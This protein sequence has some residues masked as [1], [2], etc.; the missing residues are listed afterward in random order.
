MH[1][2]EKLRT[3]KCWNENRSITQRF[4]M[5]RNSS[6]IMTPSY[7]LYGYVLQCMKSTNQRSTLWTKLRIAILKSNVLCPDVLQMLCNMSEQLRPNKVLGSPLQGITLYFI[8][9]SYKKIDPKVKSVL[10]PNR[11]TGREKSWNQKFSIV[12]YSHNLLITVQNEPHVRFSES[13]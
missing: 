8:C 7:P 4:I 12:Y 5:N 13:Y 9:I 2:T 1:F 11:C 3:E 6:P 10:L